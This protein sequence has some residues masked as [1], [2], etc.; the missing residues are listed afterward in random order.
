MKKIAF[1]P[2]AA[3][4]K[5]LAATLPMQQLVAQRKEEASRDEAI[6]AS[7]KQILID[8]PELAS[9][10]KTL[11]QHFEVISRFAP[12]IAV[13]PT[14]TGNL[15]NQLH[16]LGPGSMTHTMLGELR[17][18]QEGLTAE[19]SDRSEQTAKAVSP[20]TRA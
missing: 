17:K 10:P 3:G 5:E 11:G 15:L 7:L 1:T 13:D 18:L 6:G 2:M 20:F 19:R 14:V 8:R 4:F 16:K 12:D 9:D